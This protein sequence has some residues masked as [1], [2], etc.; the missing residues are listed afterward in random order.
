MY[1]NIAIFKAGIAN[2]FWRVY[3]KYL[4]DFKVCF[5]LEQ[6]MKTE[7]IKMWAYY[8]DDII[9]KNHGYWNVEIKPQLLFSANL[10]LQYTK[11]CKEPEVRV[12]KPISLMKIAVAFFYI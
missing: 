4:L 2:V 7:A 10:G 9:R 8:T 1:I 12:V 6:W 5:G 11:V 3:S